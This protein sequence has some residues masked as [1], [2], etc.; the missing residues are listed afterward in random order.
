VRPLDNLIELAQTQTLDHPLM[1]LGRA[2]R[3]A[4]QF[5]FDRV[6][7]E[8]GSPYNFST[9]R[10]RISA[11]C[12]RSRSASSATM[13]ALTTLCGLRRPI[14]LVSTLGTP[15]ALITART[16]PPAIT[17]VPAGAGFNS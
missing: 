10:P 5:D 15:Q 8:T 11:I 4:D 12:V 14:D 16:G 13:V 9:A 3:T 7:H 6:R 17:P 1:L 2:D